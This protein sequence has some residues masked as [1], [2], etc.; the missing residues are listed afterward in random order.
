MTNQNG[1]QMGTFLTSL[2][3][4]GYLCR[5]LLLNLFGY[6]FSVD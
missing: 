2:Y 3:H 4:C 1:G 5:N 6:C